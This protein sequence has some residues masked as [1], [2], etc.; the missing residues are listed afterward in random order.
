M[1]RSIERLRP[2]VVAADWR[3][4]A[5]AE[6]AVIRRTLVKPERAQLELF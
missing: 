2:F 3:P 1:T 5:L 4:L 6:S